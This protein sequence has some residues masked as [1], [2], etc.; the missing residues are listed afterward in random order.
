M[1][2]IRHVGIVARGDLSI[3]KNFYIALINPYK[4]DENIEQGKDIDYIIGVKNAKIK[5]CKLFSKD[6]NIEIIKYINPKV[7]INN[8]S[9]PAFSGFN[10]IAFTV[11][12]FEKARD[13]IIKNGGYCDDFK[14]YNFKGDSIRFVKYLRDPENNILEIVEM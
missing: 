6:I 9:L 10:H 3:L 14:E 5:T 12:N 2:K 1:F 7:K 4:I 13:L 11:D 8:F